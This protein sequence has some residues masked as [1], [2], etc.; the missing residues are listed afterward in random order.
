MPNLFVIRCHHAVLQ[1]SGPSQT[2]TSQIGIIYRNGRHNCNPDLKFSLFSLFSV[3]AVSGTEACTYCVWATKP[4]WVTSARLVL[5]SVQGQL[6]WISL[7]LGGSWVVL[8]LPQIKFSCSPENGEREEE[9]ERGGGMLSIHRW[10]TAKEWLQTAFRWICSALQKS[11]IGASHSKL[12]RMQITSLIN[13]LRSHS[14][15]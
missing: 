11:S 2:P 1:L 9:E 15:F 10:S 8:G 12:W 4:M 14:A 13:G 6:E 3:M 7:T 5:A